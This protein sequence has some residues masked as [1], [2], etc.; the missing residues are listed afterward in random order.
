VLGLGNIGLIEIYYI[1][2]EQ[3]NE[4]RVEGYKDSVFLWKLWRRDD[5]LVSIKNGTY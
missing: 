3:I 1:C 5:T 4:G 2:V